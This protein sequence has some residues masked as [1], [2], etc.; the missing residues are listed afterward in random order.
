MHARKSLLFKGN[1]AWVKKG[2]ENMF[3]VTMGSYDGAEICEL[4][5]LYILSELNAIHGDGSIGLYR[6]DGLG[7]F[8]NISGPQADKLR[9]DITKCFKDHG[10]KI[11]IK[12]NL[13]IVNFLDVTFDLSSG[14]Y[15]PYIKPNDTPLYI[16]TRSNHPPNIIRQ[17][18]ESISRR[19]SVLS[20]SKDA[21]EKVK[22]PY[23]AALQASGHRDKLTYFSNPTSRR[24]R[25]RKRKIIWFNPPFNKAL[26]TLVEPSCT[27]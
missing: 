4:V 15:Y 16:N 18:P 6:D 7:A 1:A 8:N 26:Q 25:N 11:T 21:F 17:L 10:L 23:E 14:T 13:K 5:G 24:K 9:K 2:N 3:D 22:P 27:Y 20:C 12:T 19:L